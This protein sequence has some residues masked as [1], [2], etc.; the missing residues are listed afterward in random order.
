MDEAALD[1]PSDR[2]PCRRDGSHQCRTGRGRCGR[3]AARRRR[4]SPAGRGRARRRSRARRARAP[5]SRRPAPCSRRSSSRRPSRRSER[6]ALRI[7]LV[8]P[9]SLKQPIGWR[10]SSLS[11][12]SHGLVEVEPDERRSDHRGR[13]A[14]A[15]SIA[16]SGI[17]RRPRC[18][19][20]LA[21]AAHE[22]P[23]RRDPRP[24][25]RAT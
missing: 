4:A 11:Q 6:G 22:S 12:I 19:A 16:S 7:A 3:R 21:R 13:D 2:A 15:R 9:R 24:R 5:P 17:R 14:R 23:L 10:H 18:R 1:D 25:G 20:P 8:A